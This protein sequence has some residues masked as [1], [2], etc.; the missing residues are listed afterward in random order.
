MLDEIEELELVLQHYAVTWGIKI[1]EQIVFKADWNQWGLDPR[2]EVI[3]Q[4]DSGE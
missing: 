3:E 4:P 2:V 1:P